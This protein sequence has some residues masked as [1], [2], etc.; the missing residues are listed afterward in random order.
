MIDKII[1]WVQGW[2]KDGPGWLKT[3]EP[4]CDFSEIC[5]FC[6]SCSVLNGMAENIIKDET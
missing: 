5:P 6:F 3:C 1:F 4:A 2:K